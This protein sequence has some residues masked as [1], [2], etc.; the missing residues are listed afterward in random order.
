[1]NWETFK[2]NGFIV[3]VSGNIF[4]CLR[5]VSLFQQVR[6]ITRCTWMLRHKAE[7]KGKLDEEKL[8]LY[9]DTNHFTESYVFPEL[10]VL[11]NII[12]GIVVYALLANGLMPRSLG[13]F[14][15]ILAIL[16]TFEIIVYHVN[17]LLFDPLKAT[18]KNQVY[19]I[20]S[21]TRMLLLLLCNMFEY[22][23]CFSIVYLFF[24]PDLMSSNYW[25]SFAYSMS[26][27]LN[28]NISGI[29]DL[30]HAIVKVVRIES[31][32]GI[33]MNLICI[34]RFINLLPDV[35]TIEKQ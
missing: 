30:P 21:A 4:N 20:K 2:Q 10:W 15:V 26:A 22:I 29:D 35:N 14:F 34:A 24:I 31:I 9:K 11:G 1:M 12:C 17:V 27:F 28:L 3:S 33:F 23:L 5:Q 16:R 8:Q 19:A 32:L 18:S 7:V 6:N 25:Q 13:C